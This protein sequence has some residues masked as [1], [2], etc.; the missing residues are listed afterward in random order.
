MSSEVDIGN[1]AIHR[2]GAYPIVALTD[3]S[4]EAQC[5]RGLFEPTRD[6]M[7]RAHPWRFALTRRSLGALSEAPAFGFA[8]QYQLP[9]DYLAIVEIASRWVWQGQTHDEPDWS[10][11]G[12]RILA[13]LEN[14]LPIRYVRRVTNADEFDPCFAEALGA[15]LA[16]EVCQRLTQHRG[17]KQ[18]CERGFVYEMGEAKKANAIEL[19]PRVFPEGSWI[20]ARA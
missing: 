8:R 6:A 16:I 4:P 14:P 5:L 11:E 2:I 18:D 3:D 15:K 10:I 1:R 19:P 7:L 12:R 9:A 20:T 17:L 13:D